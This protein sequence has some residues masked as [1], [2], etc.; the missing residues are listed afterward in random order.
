MSWQHSPSGGDD[1]PPRVYGVYDADATASVYEQYADPA[2]AHGWYEA[3]EVPA[4]GPA[5]VDAPAYAHDGPTYAYDDPAHAPHDDL[6]STA[7]MA[8]VSVPG[9]PGAYDGA[10]DGYGDAPGDDAVF[11][12]GSDR[13]RRLMRRIAVG[14]GAAC[15]VFLGVVVAGLFGSGPA[16]GKDDGKAPRA[17]H[18][19]SASPAAHPGTSGG[20]AAP[21]ATAG[22]PASGSPSHDASPS[23]SGSAGGTAGDGG[24][25]TA[26]ATG[27]APTTSA[28]FTT[29]PARGNA[30][31]KPG[32]GHGFPGSTKGPK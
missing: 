5:Y 13:K 22:G 28:P 27:S 19:P 2:A 26:P 29:V 23:P 8:A 21:A 16:G 10:Y 17:E 25:T 20:P 31:G 6:I 9:V 4:A 15:V 7:P 14:M 12:D 30:G 18:S 24:T 32:H 11:V 1:T 3:N